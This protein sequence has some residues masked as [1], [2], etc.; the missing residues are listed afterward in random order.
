MKKWRCI[1]CG[2]IHQGDSPPE[3]CP[4]CGASPEEFELIEEESVG[5]GE[6]ESKR[7]IIIGNGAAG[8]ETARILREISEAVEILLFT[9]ENHHFYSRIHLST[10]IGDDSKFDDILIHQP[11][12]YE[13]QNIRVFLDTPIASIIP[14]THEVVDRKGKSYH[15]DAL[16]IAT[17]AHP[18][19]PPI[20]G[21]SKKGVFSLRHIVDAEAIRKFSNS[22][23]SAVII[24]GG[25]LGIEAAASLNKLGLAVTVIERG[26]RIMSLQL[27]E[28]GSS[29][30]QYILQTR[31]ITFQLSAK[32]RKFEGSKFLEAVHLENGTTLPA[33]IGIISTGI[34]PN[35]RLAKDAGLHVQR[36]IVVNDYLQTNDQNIFAAGDVAEYRGTIGGI[37]PAAVDQGVVAAKNALGYSTKY[38]GT[39]PL[40]ILKVAGIDLTS[41]GKKFADMAGEKEIVHNAKENE[42]YVKLVHDGKY[43]KGAV[44]LGVS[45]IGFRLEKLI[46]N[47]KSIEEMISHFKRGEWEILKTKS[48][49]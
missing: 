6:D 42:Q 1:I 44:V 3:I 39:T 14:D 17:G 8:I 33:G 16:I 43:L 35:I 7:I 12:W 5:G 23:R 18:F 28:E 10:F 15:Y 49:R 11:A 30:L 40:H 45:G 48:G 27:D 2:Y 37:W 25:I 34:S 32:V 9:E 36:G 31:G 26:E 47:N 19:T 21:I 4:V 13:D 29:V 38:P 20:D 22:V 41:I 46:K 24:G